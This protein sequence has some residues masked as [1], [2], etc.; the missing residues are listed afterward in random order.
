MPVHCDCNHVSSTPTP[1]FEATNWL[2]IYPGF[3]FALN[4]LASHLSLDVNVD[5]KA[6]KMEKSVQNMQ[7]PS[8][9]KLARPL[10][11]HLP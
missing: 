1:H 3:F 6:V 10:P 2:N 7:I 4:L 11:P 5:T 9:I 8:Y